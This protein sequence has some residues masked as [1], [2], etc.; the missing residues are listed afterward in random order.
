MSNFSD[1]FPAAGGGGIGKTITVGDYNYIN[2]VSVSDWAKNRYAHGSNSNTGG[3]NI[4]KV[5]SSES[6]IY[7]ASGLSASDTYLTI[8]DITGAS[9]GGALLQAGCYNTNTRTSGNV[10]GP[11]GVTT[12]KLTI[13]G[14][15]PV[16]FSI[17]EVTTSSVR[18]V[19]GG[20]LTIERTYTDNYAFRQNWPYISFDATTNSF[21]SA[22]NFY[23]PNIHQYPAEFLL[24]KGS[25]FVYFTTSLKLEYKN[26]SATVYPNYEATA[27]IKTF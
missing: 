6:S 21:I 14:G 27:T 18:C 10:P 19:L 4:T 11:T 3:A 24:H 12:F 1:F 7:Q 26:N 22:S 9:N 13:D 25:P 17:G 16:E 23:L 20:F 2:A 15:T 5:S 8:A